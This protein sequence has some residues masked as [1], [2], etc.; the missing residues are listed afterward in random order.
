V[1]KQ[2]AKIV[3]ELCEN[4][5][6]FD[7]VLQVGHFPEDVTRYYF[8]Q[9]V[10]AV[11]YMHAQGYAHRDI[12]LE[13]L[14]LDSNYNLKLV[15]FGFVSSTSL[16]NFDKAGSTTYKAPEIHSKPYFQGDPAD[17]FAMGIT[18][19]VMHFGMFPFKIADKKVGLY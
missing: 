18:L 8:Q 3:L 9:L 13:N 14:M 1:N 15:D 7:Y 5:C 17:I 6:F 10:S 19:F 11:S 12:K 16:L 2:K 4:G